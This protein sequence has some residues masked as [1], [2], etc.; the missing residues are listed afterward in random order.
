MVALSPINSPGSAICVISALP[1][2]EQVVS[3]T[4]PEQSMKTP[5]G[6]C[7]STNSIAPFGKMVLYLRVSNSFS[8]STGR[9]QK[10]ALVR[11]RHSTQFSMIS[12]PYGECITPLRLP[13]V[14]GGCP[15][16]WSQPPCH[17]PRSTLTRRMHNS[18]VQEKCRSQL[19]QLRR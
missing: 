6:A 8:S 10:K 19:E 9:S 14:S 16:H 3:L 5:R 4:R 7:P 15:L 18:L 13:Q 2:P 12:I 17:N 11:R 1:S